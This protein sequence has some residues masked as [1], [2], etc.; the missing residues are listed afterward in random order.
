MKFVRLKIPGPFVIKPNILKDSRGIFFEKYRQKTIDLHG[1]YKIK[2]VQEN[3]SIS[4]K[5]VFRGFHFQISP[6]SQSKLVS[7]AKGKILDIIIDLRKNS[8][9]FGKHLKIYL[10]SFS[11]HS[12]FVPKGFAHGFFALTSNATVNYKVDNY[13][14][15]KHEKCLSLNDI[16]LKL[17]LKSLIKK[18]IVSEKDK[19]GLSLKEIFNNNYF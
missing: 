1:D 13:Y 6:Y 8:K 5:N 11:N 3:Q 10:D 14:S 15:Q 19:S 9:Y 16:D 7:V 4:K 18:S 2:F 17:N 12:L